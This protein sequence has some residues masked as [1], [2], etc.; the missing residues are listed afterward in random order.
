MR[1]RQ[2][3]IFGIVVVVLAIAVPFFVINRSSG[4]DDAGAQVAD[5]DAAAR[6]LFEANCGTCH[7]LAAAGSDG[8]V[9]PNLDDRL[10]PSG[11][12]DYESS[13]GRVL[14]A[15][16]CGVAGR[17]PAGIL[18]GENAKEV[19]AF[20]S[21]YAGQIGKGPLVNT[22]TADKPDPSPCQDSGGDGAQAQ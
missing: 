8:V 21:A 6:N 5:R 10:A 1:K 22:A 20:V 11:N 9:G 17:M 12:G 14:T 7:T 3:V 15:I 19:A 13:Y 2:F 4:L 18:T 16:T